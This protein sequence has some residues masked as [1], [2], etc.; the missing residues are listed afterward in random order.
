[1][2]IDIPYSYAVCSSRPWNQGMAE[3]LG[4]RLS[5]RFIAIESPSEL[6]LDRLRAENVKLI[7]FPHWSWMIPEEVYS[8]FECIVFH[9]TDLPFG[10]GGS[11]LQNLIAR[12][13]YDTKVSALRVV[14]ELDAGPVYLKRPLSL[15]GNAEEI[16]L[17]ASESIE[18]MI[19][20]IIDTSPTPVPQSGEATVFKRRTPKDGDIMA[21]KSLREVY[22]II[23]MLDATGY[24]PAFLETDQLKLEFS[25]AAL[26]SG[27]VVAEVKITVKI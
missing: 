26:K 4:A 18:E 10:R 8:S 17:R 2:K 22:D 1:M 11:P 19:A 5:R 27:C 14:A 24:P 25:R 3:R 23:R 16:Y 7:F 9:M 12:K 20:E 15:H 21:G 6:S 13:V